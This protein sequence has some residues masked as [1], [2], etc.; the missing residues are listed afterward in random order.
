VS[1]GDI[2]GKLETWYQQRAGLAGAQIT[3]FDAPASGV[4]NETYLHSVT[5]PEESGTASLSAVA[6][7]QP[8]TQDTPIP[9][10]DVMEQAFV[11]RKLAAVGG[12]KTPNVFW[13]ETDGRWLGRPFYIMQRLPGEA[14]FDAGTAPRDPSVLRS[15]YEQTLSMLV[16]IHAVDWERAGLGAIYCGTDAD[17]PLRVRLNQYRQHLDRASREK[18]YPLLEEAYAWLAQHMPPQTSPVLN[19][20]DARVGNLLFDGGTLTAVLD[21]E[22]ADVTA[23]EVDMG[24]FIFFE[25][26]LGSFANGERPGAMNEED[27]VKFYELKAGT[28]LQ[29]L[30]YFQRWAA[31][32]L[33]IMRLRAGLADIKNGIETPESRVDEI[34]Y[35]SIELARVFGFPEP[36]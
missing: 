12:L 11:L 19:W 33:A 8:A 7:L 24:W 29:D 20:G 3:E 16:R 32:R 28:Q 26:F 31:F 34:N 2:R 9:D 25:R 27:I 6:R 14:V 21:W 10:V 30:D 17:S 5:F 18:T 23:R 35:G 1:A 36:A 4:V 13:E 22:I 15:M